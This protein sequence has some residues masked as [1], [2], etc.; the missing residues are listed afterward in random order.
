MRYKVDKEIIAQAMILAQNVIRH[1]KK[2][3]LLQN[4]IQALNHFLMKANNGK[5]RMAIRLRDCERVVN[6]AR[7]YA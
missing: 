7:K 3:K 6:I 5:T 2:K 1:H 4:E